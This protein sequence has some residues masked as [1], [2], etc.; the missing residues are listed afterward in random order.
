METKFRASYSGAY[1][2]SVLRA[3]A[4]PGRQDPFRNDVLAS[5]NDTV[6]PPD[7]RAEDAVARD[8]HDRRST[9]SRRDGKKLPSDIVLRLLGLL[10]IALSAAMTYALFH[11]AHMQGHVAGV[12]D[13][14]L[15]LVAFAAASFGCVML[16]L[17]AHIFD[18][19]AIS[20]RW[21]TTR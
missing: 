18:E 7:G 1:G 12:L 15:A 19:V 8:E 13:Y 11:L 17:G 5:A 20:S 4:T 10:L 16:C 14:I 9:Q 6:S 2:A 3:P 21:R